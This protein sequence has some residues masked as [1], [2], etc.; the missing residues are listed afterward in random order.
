[1]PLNRHQE[2]RQ[3]E[4]AALR[5]GASRRLLRLAARL[6]ILMALASTGCSAASNAADGPSWKL[7]WADNF[8]GPA[9]SGVNTSRWEFNTG[10]VFGTGEVEADTS[11]LSNIHLDGH[12]DLDIR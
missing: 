5:T 2:G 10:Q 3:A 8:N 9:S 12:G 6:S 7:A 4:G 11:S 1:M